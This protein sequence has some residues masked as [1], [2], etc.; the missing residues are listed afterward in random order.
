MSKCD[1]LLKPGGKL[2]IQAITIPEQRYDWACRN[3]DFIQ[4]YIFPGGSLPSVEAIL[5][6]AGRNSSLQ[7]KHMEDI[8]HD[9]ARTL[10][11]WHKRFMANPSRVHALG[12]DDR[13]IRMW[14][15]YLCYCEGGFLEDAIGTAQLVMAKT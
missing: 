12:F 7:L 4:R 6:A 10:K 15:F 5:R 2:L 1:S 14:E 3:I 13:F 8:G 11:H 9:Y